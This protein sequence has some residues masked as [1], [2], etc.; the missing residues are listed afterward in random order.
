MNIGRRVALALGA[1]V[2]AAGSSSLLLAPAPWAGAATPVVGQVTDEV[3]DLTAHGE[4]GF[5][6]GPAADIVGASA[7]YQAGGLTLT[8]RALKM[9]DPRE[10]RAWQ[11]NE[12]YAE[13]LLDTNGDGREDFEA[14]Y[15]LE[16]G[17]LGG[18]VYPV[19][20]NDEDDV[21]PAAKCGLQ[22]ATFDPA[23]G[24]TAVVDPKCLG[25]PPAIGYQASLYYQAD[26]NDENTLGSDLAPDDLTEPLALGSGA[27]VPPAAPAPGSD[28]GPDGSGG[29]TP[30]APLGATT[31]TSAP[32][33]GAAPAPCSTSTAAPTTAAPDVTR[34][35]T[36]PAD[37]AA[38]A[39]GLANTGLSD[40]TMRMAGFAAGIMLIGIGILFGNRRAAVR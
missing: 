5:E 32:R 13:W 39:P 27:T 22:A 40:R 11:T 35:A 25:N 6:P 4:T 1:V 16:S 34:P 24:Y 17:Q 7:D 26:P 28:P 14:R 20:E 12:T 29:S 3:D 38:P 21:S 9:A 10:D 8:I 23:T 37:S 15:R 18:A 19:D 2:L 36:D 30:V 33:S 31:P